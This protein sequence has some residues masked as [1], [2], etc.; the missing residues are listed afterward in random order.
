[1]NNITQ[2]RRLQKLRS[3]DETLWLRY[4]GRTTLCEDCNNPALLLRLQKRL[5]AVRF[6]GLSQRNRSILL[7]QGKD[8]IGSICRKCGSTKETTGVTVGLSGT[9]MPG[10]RSSRSVT[11]N[12]HARTT[13]GRLRVRHLASNTRHR[14]PTTW[15]L[16]RFS[17]TTK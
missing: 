15:S 1:M 2:W 12:S 14:K 3:L 9:S 16:Y 8:T 7:V 17:S 10:R 4:P 11:R 13:G 5:A 6:P